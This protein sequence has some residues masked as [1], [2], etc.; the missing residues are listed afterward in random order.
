MLF[1]PAVFSRP[2]KE[3][4]RDN[5]RT[6]LRKAQKFCGEKEEQGSEQNFF[7]KSKTEQRGLC[8]DAI[9]VTG[10]E[11][12]AFLTTVSNQFRFFV[13][14]SDFY[15]KS[16]ANQRYKSDAGNNGS[17]FDTRCRIL[18]LNNVFTRF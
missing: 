14:I 5:I 7:S 9:C 8:S 2:L 13:F 11:P 16:D 6:G 15:E 17:I 10:I 3:F 12:A 1:Y 18:K 4:L